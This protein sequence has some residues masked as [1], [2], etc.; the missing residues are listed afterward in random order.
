MELEVNL[1][2]LDAIAPRHVTTVLTPFHVTTH[3]QENNFFD[4]SSNEL[5][6]RRAILRLQFANTDPHCV[7]TLKAKA[8][9]VDSVS[10]VEE[11]KEVLDAAISRE[12]LAEPA[13]P[14]PTTT[15]RSAN[16]SPRDMEN[17]GERGEQGRKMKRRKRKKIS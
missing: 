4:R 13:N 5:S 9:I 10:R 2:L 7:V 11:D 16:P 15:S 17:R 8:V 1:T 12:C 14:R 3:R 6:S